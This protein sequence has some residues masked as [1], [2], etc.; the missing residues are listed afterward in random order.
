MLLAAGVDSPGRLQE[1]GAVAAYLQVVDAGLEP[2]LN[3]LWA[4]AGALADCDWRQLPP[5]QRGKLL[6][7]LDQRRDAGAGLARD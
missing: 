3:L 2:S 6:L 7:E 5:G 1:L 4:M